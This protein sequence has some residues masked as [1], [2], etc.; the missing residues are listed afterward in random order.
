MDQFQLKMCQFQTISLSC[1]S[2]PRPV[3]PTTP[4]PQ[5]ACKAMGE[6]VQK[7]HWGGGGQWE[8]VFAPHLL[9]EC[10]RFPTSPAT[11]PSLQT[12]IEPP[13]PTQSL[14]ECQSDAGDPQRA[15]DLSHG[16]PRSTWLAT[17]GKRWSVGS[18]LAGLSC[19]L[20][21]IIFWALTLATCMNGN[22]SSPVYYLHHQKNC[23]TDTSYIMYW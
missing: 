23:K 19:S 13:A 21:A 14:S 9:I 16:L 3:L 6:T 15:P 7:Q 2:F 1:C 20:K 10:S 17:V 12:Q 4:P 5:K 18:D 22:C 11:S 8:A